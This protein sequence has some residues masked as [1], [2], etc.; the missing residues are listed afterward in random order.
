MLN[1]PTTKPIKMKLN[2]LSICIAISLFYSC[3]S[4]N[5]N[6][7]L[8]ALE[9][10]FKAEVSSSREL[11]VDDDGEKYA[12][13]KINLSNSEMLDTLGYDLTFPSIAMMLL[14]NFTEEERL[15]YGFIVVEAIHSSTGLSTKYRYK[16]SDLE[17]YRL[18]SDVFTSFS[19]NIVDGNHDAVAQKVVKKYRTPTISKE[20]EQYISGLTQD[21]GKIVGYTRSTFRFHNNADGDKLWV[22]DG[23]LNFKDGYA[24]PYH[25]TT[26]DNIKDR[27]LSGY[28]LY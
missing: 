23:F 4:K 7:A 3:N 8:A 19:K 20:L 15:K 22:Y 25:I 21:H 18:K 13:Y 14:D 27:Y 9:D 12:A 6:R 11:Q 26:T 28:Q 24:R 17:P 16:P 10:N 5:Q 1:K 2:I